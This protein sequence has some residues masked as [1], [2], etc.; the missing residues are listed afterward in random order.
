MLQMLRGTKA[1]DAE[2]ADLLEAATQAA[3]VGALQVRR[4][5]RLWARGDAARLCAPAPS[6][7]VSSIEHVF[8]PVC[9]VLVLLA[10]RSPSATCSSPPTCP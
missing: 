6:T 8:Q 4:R 2:Y 3:S 10:A 1:V 7:P 5:C 9:C